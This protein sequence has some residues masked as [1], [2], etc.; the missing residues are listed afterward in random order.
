MY[1][2]PK[3]PEEYEH[4]D[5]GDGLPSHEVAQLKGHEGPVF[6]VRYNQQGT[7]C[8]TGG[9]DRNICLWNPLRG[10]LVKKYSGH[11]YE[12]RDVCVAG[13]NSKFASCG[14]DK[15]VFIW[16][17][18]TARFIRKLKGHDSTVN[19]VTYA[20]NDD[21]LVTAG[22]DQCVKIW[23]CKSRSMDPMQT[24]KAFKD[25]VTSVVVRN[26]EII[27]CSVDGSVRRFDMRMGRMYV[28]EL[29][30]P[31]TCCAVSHDGQCVLAACLDSTLRL[32]D[33][34]TG[35]LL[36]TYQG[37]VHESVKMDAC[38]TPSDAH[39]V[40]SSETGEVLYWDLVEGNV[41]KRI[42]AHTGVVCS[43]AMHPQG[44]HLLTSALDGVV[45]VWAAQPPKA[46]AG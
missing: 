38:L 30:Q 26:A 6:A 29:Y 13:D 27:A 8:V 24:M 35:E 7:Y 36:A 43:L 11:G 4:Q 18:S 40:G 39:V 34:S 5:P 3:L 9:K 28:D 21:C 41:V 44:S 16:D 15:Q 33:R 42:R 14:G 46:V 19:A 23:D 45:K 17:V 10:I 12:V 25:S 2:Y 37:H 31:V 20:A 22:Y 1:S 32:L